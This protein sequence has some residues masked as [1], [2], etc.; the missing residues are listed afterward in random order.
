[1]AFRLIALLCFIFLYSCDNV[2]ETPEIPSFTLKGQTH[3]L[4]NQAKLYL[5]N[6]ADN[7]V[8]ASTSVLDNQFEFKGQIASPP[9]QVVL[10][11][12]DMS[13]AKTIWLENTE[14]EFFA[15]SKPINKGILLGSKTANDAQRLDSMMLAANQDLE[16]EILI[17]IEFIT[18]HPASRVSVSALAN[19]ANEMPAETVQELFNLLSEEN[20]MSI[21][22]RRIQALL[23]EFTQNHQ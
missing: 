10:H 13:Q 15:N 1:M 23:N 4:P 19:Y 9:A 18:A 3:Q 22:G 21:F 5:R 6:L 14:M 17:A 20:K 2:P 8:L 11:N 7:R 12:E 16:A